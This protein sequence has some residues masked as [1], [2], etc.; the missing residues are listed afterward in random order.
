M[1]GRLGNNLF[2]YA[3]GRVLAERHS[4]PLLLDGSWFNGEGWSQVSCIRRLPLKAKF[5]RPFSVG[6][7]ALRKFTGKHHWEFLG[8]PM[9]MENPGDHSFDPSLFEAPADCILFGYFQS[10]RYFAGMEET[11]R[12]EINLE[13]VF[14][15]P[16][17]AELAAELVAP[18]SVAVHVRRGDFTALPV[19]AV[20][21]DAYYQEA[22]NRLRGRLGSPRFYI[23]SDDPAWCREHF[24]ASDQ[25]VV[26]LP[27]SAE[28]PLVDLHLMSLASHHIIA[29]STYSWWAAWIGKKPSQMVLCPSRWVNF[30]IRTPIAEKICEGW[31]IVYPSPAT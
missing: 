22:M 8:K 27:E 7:R 28:D 1:L 5:T 3:F 18:G 17:S 26:N 21:D 29:N 30:G 19:F 20:C 9:V 23:F 12:N 2:E 4:V 15:E 31:E 11:L 25:T 6:S 16:P 10:P 24:T 14:P 13:K